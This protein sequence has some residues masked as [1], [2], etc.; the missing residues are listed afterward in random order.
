MSGTGRAII[1]LRFAN[2]S[3]NV[4][5]NPH[6]YLSDAEPGYKRTSV[7]AN[8]SQAYSMR[9]IRVNRLHPAILTWQCAFCLASNRAHDLRPAVQINHEFVG[10]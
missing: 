8:T 4:R 6:T 3:P 2:A 9:K 10:R 7:N 5:V 1:C